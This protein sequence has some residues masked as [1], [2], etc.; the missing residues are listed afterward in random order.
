MS[1]YTFDNVNLLVCDPNGFIR[2]ALRAGLNSLGFRKVQD[3]G[4]YSEIVKAVE[5]DSVDVLVCDEA[6]PGGDLSELVRQIRNH[7]IGDNPFIIAIFITD[8][9][10]QKMISKAINSG[11]DD[12]LLKPISTKIVYNRVL[13]LVSSRKPF[14]V[15]STYIGPDRHKT[16]REDSKV[17]LIDVPNPLKIK[18]T[19]EDSAE[20]IQ[21]EIDKFTKEINAQKMERNAA[22]IDYLVNFIHPHYS[23]GEPDKQIVQHLDDLR[24]AS[25]DINRRL[26]GTSYEHVGELCLNMLDLA[27]RIRKQF[28][29]PETK[30]LELLPNL[31]AAI[32]MAFDPEKRTA[33]LAREISDSMRRR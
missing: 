8:T 25:E 4:K 3:T 31:S 24:M 1:E 21:E 28:K 32:K 30:D 14:V 13:H 2:S 15:T 11:V 9:P 33:E 18:A 10:T 7:K 20:R 16:P 26:R 6:L 27:N 23:G 19:G 12:I 22:H 5:S 17:P 29:K